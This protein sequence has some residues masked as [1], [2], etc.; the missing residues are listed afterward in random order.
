MPGFFFSAIA[1]VAV[2]ITMRMPVTSIPP[3]LDLLGLGKTG[4]ALLV[5]IPPLCFSVGA[6][7]APMLRRRF[8][9][10]R[11]IFA[12]VALTGT[13]VALRAVA[14]G[15]T[16]FL[17]TIVACLGIAALNVLV[18]STVKERFSHRLAPM[19]AAYTGSITLG[20]GLGAGLTVPMFNGSGGTLAVALGIWMVPSVIALAFW[21]PQLRIARRAAPDH[22]HGP[23]RTIWRNALAWH[24]L[25]FVGLPGSLIFYGPVSWMPQIYEARGF[26]ATHAGY[27]LMIM[28]IANFFG[29]LG[30]PIL[31][32][33]AAD[34]R[35]AVSLAVVLAI[36]GL[37]GIIFAPT[38]TAVIWMLIL[39]A[40]QGAGLSLSLLLINLRAGD[41]ETA[42]RLSSMAQCGGYLI[43]A[44]GPFVMGLLHVATGGW[45]MPL[46]FVILAM[47]ASWPSGLIAGR[48]V[49]I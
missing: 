43:G 20:S 15:W 28:S 38:G 27:L 33:R 21:L 31:A 47:L 41:A 26:D 8:G 6:L 23:P 5:S 13:T 40:A 10:E 37:L 3:V 49:T 36:I 44:V 14:P 35:P 48:K 39:G 12:L 29:N 9:E 25:I 1:V 42:A 4:E 18:P 11:A 7:I 34:Q 2:A 16:L 24:V 19:M 45:V 46:V 17:W 30:A 32:A 22:S